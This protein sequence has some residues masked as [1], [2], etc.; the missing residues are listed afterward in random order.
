MVKR[1][2]VDQSVDLRADFICNVDNGKIVGIMETV[3]KIVVKT[4]ICVQFGLQIHYV[5]YIQ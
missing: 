2:I 5:E 1:F 4:H 3:V